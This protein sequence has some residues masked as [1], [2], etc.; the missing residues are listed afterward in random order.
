MIKTDSTNFLEGGSIALTC[1]ITNINSSLISQITWFHNKNIIKKNQSS[2]F[3]IFNNF[4]LK[5]S[6]LSH[7]LHNGNYYCEI[8][9]ILNSIN[10]MNSTMFVLMIECKN[11]LFHYKKVAMSFSV[12]FKIQ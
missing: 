8:E 2:G 12:H 5:I 6:N 7:L 10:I 3:E 1:T 4:T 11:S 9:F